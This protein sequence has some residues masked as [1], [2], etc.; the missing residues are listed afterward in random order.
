MSFNIFLNLNVVFRPNRF[1]GSPQNRAAP[2]NLNRAAGSCGLC[3]V[4]WQRLPN[5]PRAI[6]WGLISKA[7]CAVY[8]CD[9]AILSHSTRSSIVPGG[10][11]RILKLL[12]STVRIYAYTP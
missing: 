1:N 11:S 12:S 5:Y 4:E 10:S 3:G 9:V 8:W 7:D 2:G 6:Y